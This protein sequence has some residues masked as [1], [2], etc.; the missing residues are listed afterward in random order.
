LTRGRIKVGV[1]ET[2]IA[3]VE[4]LGGANAG[5]PSL[6]LPH[7][8]QWGRGYEIRIGGEDVL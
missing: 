2:R 3:I 8:K 4:D 7:M 1:Q 6:A 5:T